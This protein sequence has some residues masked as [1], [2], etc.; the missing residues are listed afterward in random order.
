MVQD[1]KSKV[2]KIWKIDNENSDW[3]LL[4]VCSVTHL[5]SGRRLVYLVAVFFSVFQRSPLLDLLKP[6]RLGG[7]RELSLDITPHTTALHKDACL[8]SEWRLLTLTTQDGKKKEE[9]EEEEEGEVSVILS[10]VS[11]SL[12]ILDDVM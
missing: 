9:E 5:L 11:P 4:S 12:V 3:W 7:L 8:Q 2:I 10:R 1:E 6:F